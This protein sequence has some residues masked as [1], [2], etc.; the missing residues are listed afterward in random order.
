MTDAAHTHRKERWRKRISE[1]RKGR[2]YHLVTSE[3]GVNHIASS[4]GHILLRGRL[5]RSW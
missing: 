2:G 4:E 1:G 3:T 5:V